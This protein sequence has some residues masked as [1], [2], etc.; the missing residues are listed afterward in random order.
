ME[1]VISSAFAR[2]L[3][4]GKIQ[5]NFKLDLKVGY[6]NSIAYQKNSLRAK[7]GKMF[8][9]TGNRNGL[10]GTTPPGFG[11]LAFSFRLKPGVDLMSAYVVASD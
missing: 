3:F 11:S 4:S 2:C 10:A 1:A 6:R 7:A 8:G 9:E 5:R